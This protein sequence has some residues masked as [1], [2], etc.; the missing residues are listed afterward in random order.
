[1]SLNQS[2]GY[3]RW[4]GLNNRESTRWQLEKGISNAIGITGWGCTQ[5]SFTPKKHFTCFTLNAT[6]KTPRVPSKLPRT[7]SALHQTPYKSPNRLSY[8]LQ[9][10]TASF[11]SFLS[12]MNRRGWQTWPTT[13][14]VPSLGRFCY[15]QVLQY[16]RRW[17][18]LSCYEYNAGQSR[19]C[20][21]LCCRYSWYTSCR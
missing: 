6:D 21:P 12:R 15:L 17:F 19:T 20:H 2:Y 16:H 8:N 5:L 10:R 4:Y 14:E 18:G 9:T 13:W 3:C 7:R 11:R 1:M